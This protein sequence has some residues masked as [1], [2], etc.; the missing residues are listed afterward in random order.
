MN[1]HPNLL[2]VIAALL[3]TLLFTN[4]CMM[5]Q[6]LW[7][8]RKYHPAA[9]PS[10]YLAAS[11]DRPLILVGYREQFDKTQHIRRR[12]FWID[13][14]E[15][16]E[17]F[18]KKTFVNPADYP[19]LIY[20]PLI[21][22]TQGTNTIPPV[23]YAAAETVS[24]PGFDLWKDG[25]LLGR[26]QLPSYE[27]DAPVTTETVIKTPA[28]LILDGAIIVLGAAAIVGLCYLLLTENSE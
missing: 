24:K 6:G 23:G 17:A 10:L 2:A 5:T 28:M 26:F 7:T 9:Q 1:R 27:G 15:P 12:S 19:G 13:L 3:A 8:D 22:V 25:Q 21:G 16:Y 14:T 4:G 11:P 20:I 18:E